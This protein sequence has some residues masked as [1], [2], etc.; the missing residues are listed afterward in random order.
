M[1]RRTSFFDRAVLAALESGVDQVVVV[2]AGYDGR[3]LRFA[4]PG[5]RWFEVDH[6]ATQR[7]K[8]ARLAAVGAATEHVTF[9]A[10]DLVTGDLPRSLATSGF[11]PARPALFTVEGLLGYLTRE[12]TER[13]L[14]ELRAV[15]APDSRLALAVPLVPVVTGGAAELRARARGVIL[16]AIGEPHL[17]R[18]SPDEVDDVL[19]ESGWAVVAQAG[20]PLRHQGPRGVLLVAAPVP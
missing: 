14:A 10:L 9:V 5:V 7:D 15:A 2:A 3:P 18:F 4:T 6:P 8:R 11:D 16:A 19:V 17:H 13:L 1:E 12:T 20:A